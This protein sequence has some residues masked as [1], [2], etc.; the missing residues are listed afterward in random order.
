MSLEI[1]SLHDLLDS[2]NEE[3]ILKDILSLFES[4]ECEGTHS[5]K[6]IEAF[7]HN[8]N[9][10]VDFEKKGVSRTYLVFYQEDESFSYLA[11]YFSIANKNLQISTENFGRLSREK[12]KYFQEFGYESDKNNYIAPAILLGQF[13]K[14]YNVPENLEDHQKVNGDDLMASAKEIIK[15]AYKLVGGKVLYLECEDHGKLTKFYEKHGFVKLEI[16]R[17]EDDLLIYTKKLSKL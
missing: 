15:E 3:D 7:L 16:T 2:N 5:S 6:D 13:G 4:K 10:A 9:K 17:Q 8:R 1:V 12:R 11:G 14:N